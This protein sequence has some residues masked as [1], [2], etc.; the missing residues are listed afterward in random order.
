MKGPVKYQELSH[1]FLNQIVSFILLSKDQQQGTKGSV[2]MQELKH[3]L[4]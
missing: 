2:Y 4:Q 1:L 3:S